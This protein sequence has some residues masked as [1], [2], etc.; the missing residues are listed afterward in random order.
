ML[1]DGCRVIVQTEWDGRPADAMVALHAFRSAGSIA[2]FHERH[3]DRGVAVVLTGTDV[4]GDL[5]RTDAA[6]RS[7]QVANRIVTLQEEALAILEQPLR[8]KGETIFQ[9]APLLRP[10]AKAKGRLDCVAAGHLRQVKDPAT[11]FA[12]V[13]LLPP[14][15]PIHVRHFGAPL[16]TSLGHEAFALQ[17]HDRRYT[18]LGAKPHGRVRAAIHAA[19]VLIHP[20]RAEGGANVI[21]EAVNSGTPVVASRI[22]GNIGMLGKRYSGYFDPGDAAALARMLQRALREP[23]FVARLREQCDSRRPLFRPATE[24]RAVRGLVAALL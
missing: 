7:L 14:G 10:K 19:H 20:S 6:R 16:E 18:Y 13:R 11:L 17:A 22:P 5:G 24:A 3:P 2:R 15:L 23:A 12:A 21:V 1:R 8:A 4:Y 9:S